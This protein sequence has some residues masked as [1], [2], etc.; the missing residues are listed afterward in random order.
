MYGKQQSCSLLFRTVPRVASIPLAI[1]IVLA[2]ILTLTQS[3]TAQTYTVLF[4]FTGG[5]NGA[6][7]EAGLTM[8]RAGKSLRYDLSRRKFESRHCL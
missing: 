6:Y 2:L 8:D 7:P 5:Q 3:A 1:V 4:N